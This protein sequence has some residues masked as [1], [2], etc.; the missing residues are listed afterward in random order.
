MNQAFIELQLDECQ[1]VKEKAAAGAKAREDLQRFNQQLQYF[2]E[3]EDREAHVADLRV[4]P[5]L[6]LSLK[7][8]LTKKQ[9]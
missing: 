7:A 2:R 8:T 3:M 4:S 1:A 9:Q 6:S 5:S